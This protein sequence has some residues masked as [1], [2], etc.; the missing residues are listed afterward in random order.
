VTLAEWLVVLGSN[1]SRFNGPTLPV[2]TFCCNYV[3]DFIRKMND[4]KDGYAYRLPTEAEWEYAARA[5]TTGIYTMSDKV[6]DAGI[7][8]L[9]S[10]DRIGWYSSNSRGTTHPIGLKPAN[11]WG[12]RDMEGNVWEWVQDWYSSSYYSVSDPENPQGP[13]EGQMV[14]SGAARG[15]VR[16]QRG[17]SWS[18]SE[19]FARVSARSGA[20]PA[21]KDNLC[22]F[23]LV[24]TP[25]P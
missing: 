15:A 25:Q 8:S 9:S 19:I 10:L 18:D 16:I 24:R 23:R 2:E 11:A 6:D 4:R 7:I 13:P 22:G 12:L 14:G 1:P 5:G 3:Q 20:N 21:T 17:G